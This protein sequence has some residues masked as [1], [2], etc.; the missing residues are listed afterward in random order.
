MSERTHARCKGFIC[1]TSELDTVFFSDETWV[2]LDSYANIQNYRLWGSEN[3]HAYME[4]SLHPQ[5]LGYGAVRSTISELC[6]HGNGSASAMCGRIS[7]LGVC[8]HFGTMQVAGCW[9]GLAPD[10]G[11]G[12]L[13][14]SLSVDNSVH[15]RRPSAWF[16][17]IR[18]SAI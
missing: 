10:G 12:R 6:V 15:N 13:A 3:H 7:P 4:T 16:T 2:Y 17:F 14:G 11:F 18:R 8:V 9:S 1:E 5:K